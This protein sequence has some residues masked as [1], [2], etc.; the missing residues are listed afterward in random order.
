MVKHTTIVAKVL[1]FI[2]IHIGCLATKILIPR[3]NG[4][5]I[6]VSTQKHKDLSTPIIIISSQSTKEPSLLPSIWAQVIV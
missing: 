3:I 6:S 5:L 2:D 1:E 4:L